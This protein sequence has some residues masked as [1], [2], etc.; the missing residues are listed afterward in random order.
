M[1]VSGLPVLL[2]LL[3]T[4][5]LPPA[6]QAQ[7]F[8]LKELGKQLG[9]DEK[10]GNLFDQSFNTLRALAPI[11]YEE[12]RALGGALAVEAFQRFGGPY[13]NQRLTQYI[14]LVGTTVALHSDRADIPY[15]F[16]IL[17]SPHPN[18][19]ATPGGYVF[20]S[21][22]L[23]RLLGSEAELAGVLGH[24]IAHIS[25]KHALRTLQRSQV[26]HRVSQLT[27]SVLDKD[28]AIFDRLINELSAKIFDQG[29][30]QNMELEA[31]RLGTE[32]AMRVGY[33]STALARFLVRLSQRQERRHTG[34]F[35]THPDPRTRARHLRQVARAPDAPNGRL[36][37]S[38]FKRVL[39]KSGIRRQ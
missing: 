20:V 22:G 34:L 5:L 28:P 1:R 39:E 18:A 17:N 24:E 10:T 9:L 16:A 21:I 23:L 37:A 12:E 25:R 27:L 3:L 13:N 35:Q 38:R 29:L 33:Q 6:V 15:Y 11:G 8:N 30:D 36:L 19:F 7:G 26:L 32:Y 14:T 2:V 4:C 31:D